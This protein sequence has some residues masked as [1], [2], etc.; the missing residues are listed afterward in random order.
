VALDFDLLLAEAGRLE[1]A[2][3]LKALLPPGFMSGSPGSEPR[4]RDLAA[5][6]RAELRRVYRLGG[7]RMKPLPFA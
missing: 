3:L 6:P 2:E 1:E 7:R 4:L 5:L